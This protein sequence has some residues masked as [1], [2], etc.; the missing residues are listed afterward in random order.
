MAWVGVGVIDGGGGLVGNVEYDVVV[1]LRCQLRLDSERDTH[2]WHV[3]APS[4]AKE[5]LP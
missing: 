1:T 2:M 3:I 5:R 4:Y